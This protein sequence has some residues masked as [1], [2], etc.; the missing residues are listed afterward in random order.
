MTDKILEYYLRLWNIA[1]KKNF[2]IFYS[3]GL[4]EMSPVR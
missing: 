3:L 2:T 1:L 4:N